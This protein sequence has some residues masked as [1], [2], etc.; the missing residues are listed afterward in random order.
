MNESKKK[1][2]DELIGGG[3]GPT[4]MRVA[5]NIIGGVIPFA[6]GLLSGAASAWSE[7]EQKRIN[8]I[9]QI[10]LSLQ[11]D[12]IKEIGRT[13][14]EVLA[15]LDLTDENIAKRMESPE[16]LSLVKKAFRD[17]SA[18]E[19]E[20][21]RVLIRNLITNAAGINITTDD[22][23]SMFLSW[24]DRYSETHFKVIAAIYNK[25]GISRFE[26]WQS[27]DGRQVSDNSPEADLFKFI[28]H[29][30]TTG[31]VIRQH[32]EVN[33]M[34]EFIKQPRSKPNKFHSNTY[35][36]PFEDG[37]QY[38]LTELGKQFVHYTMNEIVPRIEATTSS[39]AQSSPITV[40]EPIKPHTPYITLE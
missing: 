33:Y 23:I 19:S 12:E 5:L 28:F 30:L 26:V 35:I 18:A 11:E 36:S 8:D 4:S 29:E 39:K 21:K 6:G 10:W 15:R 24:I 14:F 1:E 9:L 25:D 32:R 22:V 7:S 37:K 16:Y 3:I 13:M 17:W 31:Y 27:V 2:L 20:D 34:G 38:E 40:P